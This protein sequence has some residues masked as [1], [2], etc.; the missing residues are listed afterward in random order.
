[1]TKMKSTLALALGFLVYSHLVNVVHS[2]SLNVGIKRTEMMHYAVSPIRRSSWPICAASSS[3]SFHNCR[4]KSSLGMSDLPQVMTPDESSLE[5]SEQESVRTDP[6][7]ILTRNIE[8]MDTDGIVNLCVI[9]VIGVVVLSRLAS[10][11]VGMMRGWT[12]AEMTVRIPVD[13]WLS[14]SAVLNNSPIST[15]AVTSATVYTIGDFIAQRTEGLSMGELDRPRILRSLL[16]G[17]IGHG[18]LSHIW[19]ESNEWL[20]NNVLH[21]TEWWSFI[22]KIVLDQTTWGPFWNNTYIL[23]LGIMKLDKLEDIWGDMKRTTLPLLISGLKLWPLAHCVTYGLIPV[24]NRLLWVDFVEILWVTILASSASGG[25]A[26]HGGGESS[27]LDESDEKDE[28]T[29]KVEA[30]ITESVPLV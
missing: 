2:F 29:G 15:K 24:E 11:D 25:D 27:P 26:G 3:S 8:S 1:M 28:I 30:L 4:S 5:E 19:F 14:Y 20:F 16:A 22:P 9:A 23:L 21:W 7:R 6:V 17:L 12:A 10:V 18:P 13:N